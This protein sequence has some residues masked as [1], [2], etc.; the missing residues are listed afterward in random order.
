MLQWNH[1]R[2]QQMFSPCYFLKM[3][4]LTKVCNLLVDIFNYLCSKKTYPRS[5]HRKYPP[6]KLWN[7]KK[8]G[9]PSSVVLCCYLEKYMGCP[10][11]WQETW[12]I[13]NKEWY[14]SPNICAENTKILWKWCYYAGNTA[15]LFQTRKNTV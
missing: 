9:I 8:Y 11:W 10:M 3:S 2:F 15:G 5:Y 6:S 7:R 4:A 14:G 1:C 13:Q 12:A